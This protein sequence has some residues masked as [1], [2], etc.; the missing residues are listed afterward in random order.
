[1][2]I[3]KYPLKRAFLI[4]MLLNLL[5]IPQN[6]SVGQ[7]ELDEQA[8]LF[9]MSI[10]ELMDV[11]ITVASKIPESTLEAPGVVVVVPR[12][13][14]EIYG[15]R[16]LHQLMQR[17]PSVYTRDAFPYSDNLAAFR[18][19]MS[20]VAEMHTLIL[21]NGRPIRESAQGHNVNMYTTLPLTSLD[22]VELIRGPGSVLY[23]SNAFTGV[24]NLK[25]RPVPE[26]YEF[27]V[28]GMAGSYG[29]YD[30]T[31]SGEDSLATSDSL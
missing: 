19:D 26:Q 14:F 3:E 16:N 23:G 18:G 12:N 5:S 28:S 29:Y 31:F 25:S 24:V 6:V 10:E 27:S 13:E 8:D 2:F 22:S 21:F 30:T 15:D 1:M 17:Q 20:T 7:Q 4:V 9:E 11:E